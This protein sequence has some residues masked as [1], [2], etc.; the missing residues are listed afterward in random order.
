MNPEK[1]K[2]YCLAM[3]NTIYQSLF[4]SLNAPQVG[5]WGGS[6]HTACWYKDMPS[7]RMKVN[8]MLHKGYVVISYD[9]GTDVFQVFLLD[10]QMQEVK[11]FNEVYCDELGTLIDENIERKKDMSD[12]QYRVGIFRE[13]VMS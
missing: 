10:N 12:A 8:G 13:I 2:E 7:L 11:H 4:F 5:S 9:E 1:E 3:A 6:D